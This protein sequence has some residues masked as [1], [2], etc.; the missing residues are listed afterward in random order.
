MMKY[1]NIVKQ[2]DRY[3]LRED[4]ISFMDGSSLAPNKLMLDKDMAY[5]WTGAGWDVRDVN[6]DGVRFS[7]APFALLLRILE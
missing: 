5:V 7:R 2:A 3:E 4:Y 6:P 1:L